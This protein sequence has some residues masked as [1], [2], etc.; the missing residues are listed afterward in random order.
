[1]PILH[2]RGAGR[3]KG[4]LF[5]LAILIILALLWYTQKIVNGLRSEA[6]QIL[7]FY[8]QFYARAASEASDSDLSFIFE[9]II[10]RTDFP[11]ILCDENFEP[12]TWKGID[13]PP[14]SANSPAA[15]AEVRKIMASMREEIDPIPLTYTDPQTGQPRILSYLIYGDSK[16][17]KQLQML[18]YAEIIVAG[19]FI[20]VGFWGFNSIR[21]NEQRLIWVGMAKETAHQLGTPISSLLGWI[22]LL[23]SKAQVSNGDSTLNEMQRDVERLS[24]VASRFS[25]IGS[26]ADLKEQDLMPMLEDVIKYFRRRL[27]QMGKEVHLE[28]TN[29]NPSD[30]RPV[31]I[32]RDLFE[33]V[34]EN[35]IKNSLDAIE[36]PKGEIILELKPAGDNRHRIALDIRDNGRGI[37][38]AVRKNIFKP[39]FSTKKRGW[40]LGLSLA[41][42]IVEDYHHG[43]LFLKETRLGEGSTMRILL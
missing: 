15:R 38:P 14:D 43:K 12:T 31:A 9:H 10:Q 20:L 39:G 19:M 28:I 29:A 37:E 22:E 4:F 34:L 3:F 5:A 27:P 16:L 13:I 36:K 26:Q 42:R 23:R 18:P 17:I 33:W 32:N 30:I 1:M 21:R 41:K 11:I 7:L 24:K 8:T 40:G 2:Y 6:R 35:L 25:Q